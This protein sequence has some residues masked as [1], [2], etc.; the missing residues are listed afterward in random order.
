MQ[1]NSSKSCSYLASKPY[2]PRRNIPISMT[3]DRL[4]MP[5]YLL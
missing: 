4:A 2:S 1:L 5:L 3:A